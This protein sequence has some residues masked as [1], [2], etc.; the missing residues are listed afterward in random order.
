M[1]SLQTL[2]R[3]RVRMDVLL[4]DCYRFRLGFIPP[5]FFFRFSTAL[6]VKWPFFF[7]ADGEQMLH[8]GETEQIA[9][10][11]C[12]FGT[13][14]SALGRLTCTINVMHHKHVPVSHVVASSCCQQCKT[15]AVHRTAGGKAFFSGTFHKRS[16]RGFCL[17]CEGENIPPWRFLGGLSDLFS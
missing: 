1:Q 3:L 12:R 6:L 9:N 7:P 17:D 2:S 4:F 15:S 13:R 11:R 5:F 10:A 14:E 8:G 16:R